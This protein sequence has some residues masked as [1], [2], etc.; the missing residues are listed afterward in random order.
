MELGG[1]TVDLELHL[2]VIVLSAGLLLAY[3]W[4]LRTHGGVF[5]PRRG[6]PAATFRQQLAFTSGVLVLWFAS[7]S[8][9][10]DIADGYLFSAHMLQHLLQAFVAAP[11]IL[12]GIPEWMGHLLLKDRR[13]RGAV[14][15]LAKPLVAALIFNT[16]L[17]FIHWPRIVELM[18]RSGAVHLAS[19]VALFVAGLIMWLPVLSPVREVPRLS[20]P[21]QMIYLFVQTILPTVP[22]SWLTF[23]EQ[24]LY[25]IYE[26]FPRMWGISALEDMR[27]AGVIMKTGGGFF[28]W[29]IITVLYFKWASAEER[30]ARDGDDTPSAP[31]T[32]AT[33]V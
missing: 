17:L 11:L 21:G 27:I 19:H 13:I 2:E 31:T 30:S 23:G 14:Q 28:L 29:G 16:V 1:V 3:F 6:E 33:N 10:H 5:H 18:V 7:G 25:G 4:S 9:L 26:T 22:A 15:G 8:P 12:M 32:P 20:L 24:P